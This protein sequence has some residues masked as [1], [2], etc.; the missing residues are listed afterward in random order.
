[1]LLAAAV[2]TVIV[3]AAA[4]V[5]AAVITAQTVDFTVG[6]AEHG[7]EA[8]AALG[9]CG[10]RKHIQREADIFKIA[11]G[12]TG[13]SSGG[14]GFRHAAPQ[15]IDHHIHRAEQFYDGKQADGNIDRHRG[16]H[17]SI[18][19]RYG[20][21]ITFAAV[22]VMMVA[23]VTA[24]IGESQFRLQGN[25]LAFCNGEGAAVGIA[26]AIEL[27]G[28][29]GHVGFCGTKEGHPQIVAVCSGDAADETAVG[30]AEFQRIVENIFQFQIPAAFLQGIGFLSQDFDTIQLQITDGYISGVAGGNDDIPFTEHIVA[31]VA[32][33]SCGTSRPQNVA[34]QAF[35]DAALVEDLLCD[36]T[37]F[38]C[39]VA[40]VVIVITAAVSG[41][42]VKFKS[43][44]KTASL[45]LFVLLHT[46]TGAQKR[47]RFGNPSACILDGLL[48]Y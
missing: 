32:V 27:V 36:D 46:M 14:A 17:G 7:A 28:G 18:A 42:Q 26:A 38:P 13:H 22:V 29:G 10:G 45:K 31:A 48:L 21:G 15:R 3:I 6:R 19:V 25:G 5:A 1:M 34:G 11:A 20:D 30:T 2:V 8:A 33:S 44:H 9:F 23:G 35:L 47:D 41:G 37:G 39:A 40:V 43:S 12:V 24:A 4:V 16:T